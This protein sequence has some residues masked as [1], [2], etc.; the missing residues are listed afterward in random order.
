MRHSVEQSDV[1]SSSGDIKV[2][3]GGSGI[4]HGWGEVSVR[5]E[6]KEHRNIWPGPRRPGPSWRTQRKLYV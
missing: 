1:L 3:C 4:G 5:M 2:D 6:C